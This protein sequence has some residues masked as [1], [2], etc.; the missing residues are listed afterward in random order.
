MTDLDLCR[1]MY[2]DKLKVRAEDFGA[3]GCEDQRNLV[4]DAIIE[5]SLT[6]ATCYR[7]EMRRLL[8][9]VAAEGHDF[10]GG[11]Q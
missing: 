3:Q 2:I 4:L 5:L 8:D 7:T 10:T 9:D 11:A 6:F 1:L